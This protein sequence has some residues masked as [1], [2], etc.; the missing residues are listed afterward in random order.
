MGRSSEAASALPVSGLM[1][2]GI[3]KGRLNF[4][5]GKDESLDSF[6]NEVMM[7]FGRGVMMWE[8]Y[9]S[10]DLLSDNEWNAIASL[11]NGLKRI[12][13]TSKNKNDLR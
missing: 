10:P 8:L 5:G 6:T 2:H 12:N 9:V 4:L 13:S 3:I 7:Y 1:I 11:L